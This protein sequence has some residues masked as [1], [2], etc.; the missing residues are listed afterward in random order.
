MCLLV[1][2]EKI[3]TLWIDYF[4]IVSTKTQYC[5]HEVR[6]ISIKH[7]DSVSLIFCRHRQFCYIRKMYLILSS[8]MHNSY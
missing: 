2:L 6:Q 3:D 4:D 8:V 5:C 7:S 1:K